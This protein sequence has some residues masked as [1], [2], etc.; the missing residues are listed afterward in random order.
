MYHKVYAVI[1]NNSVINIFEW[2]E[3][4]PPILEEGLTLY[5]ITENP[6][7]MVGMCY[8]PETDTFT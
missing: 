7:V 8:D 4:N 5:D 1:Q 3:E 6:S 2:E